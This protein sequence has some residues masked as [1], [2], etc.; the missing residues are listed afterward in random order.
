MRKYLNTSAVPLSLA[1]FLA[2]DN[3]DH[4]SET[5]SVTTL[6]KPLK[7]VIL[8]SRVPQEDALVDIS[9]LVS[10]RLGTAVHDGIE[11]SW[12]NGYKQAMEALGYPQRV[13]DRVLVNPT[14]DQLYDGCIP[15]YLE[16]RSSKQVEGRTVSGKFDFVGEGR[17]EDFKNTTVFTWVNNTKDDDYVLQGSMYRWLNQDIVTADT[18]A[19]QFIFSDWSAAQAKAGSPKYPP[20]RTMEKVYRLMSIQETEAFVINKIRAI[21]AFW[22]AEESAMP[23]CTDSDLW[24]KEP[25]FK[26]Y[27]NPQKTARSTKNFD[28]KQDAYIQMAQDG[29]VGIVR[30]VPGQVTACKYCPAFAICKQKDDLIAAG[31]LIL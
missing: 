15:V 24:R 20:Q 5:I 28:N 14:P 19:I 8:A 26:Y 7:Q 17:L 9:N 11:R 13:I 31:D 21:N 2:T 16:R 22:N 4:D 18:M 12:L 10:S 6:I 27:K 29:N 1:V 25:Q 3:Y 30:E 23:A